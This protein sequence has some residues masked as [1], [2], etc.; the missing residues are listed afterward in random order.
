[1]KCIY[2]QC[3][4]KV[5]AH[6][7]TFTSSNKCCNI[8][9]FVYNLAC[10][11][12]S[13]SFLDKSVVK[14]AHSWPLAS[15]QSHSRLFINDGSRSSEPEKASTPLNMETKSPSAS[16]GD[17]KLAAAGLGGRTIPWLKLYS[18]SVR[19]S[20]TMWLETAKCPKTIDSCTLCTLSA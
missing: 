15:G 11:W 9:T 3:S 10:C 16:W 8:L 20:E 14:H 1:M 2:I 13:S 4:S 18:V 7:W 17:N 6:L 12:N 19:Q 5:N